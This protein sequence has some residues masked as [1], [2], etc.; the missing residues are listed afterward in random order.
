MMYYG[1]AS[2]TK[3]SSHAGRLLVPRET[4]DVSGLKFENYC[5]TTT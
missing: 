3:D 4:L 5:I 1:I 2:A